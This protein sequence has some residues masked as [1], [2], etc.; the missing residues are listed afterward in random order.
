[1]PCFMTSDLP[2][3]LLLK[4]TEVLYAA[5]KCIFGLSGSALPQVGKVQ[6]EAQSATSTTFAI[7]EV[8]LHF[9]FETCRAFLANYL[10]SG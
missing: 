10:E 7:A 3:Q 4:F 2:K 1:M 9:F 5:V 6:L 8:A